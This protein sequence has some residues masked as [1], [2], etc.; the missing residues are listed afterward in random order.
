MGPLVGSSLLYISYRLCG[1]IIYAVPS[2]FAYFISIIVV[3]VCVMAF[4]TEIPSDGYHRGHESVALRPDNKSNND[5]E[6]TNV[7]NAIIACMVCS[8]LRVCITTN[9]ECA[10]ALILEEEY[11][12]TAYEAGFTISITLLSCI[13]ARLLWQHFAMFFLTPS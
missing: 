7:S 10:M 8:F 4:P 5:D 12:F 9:L 13:P 3:V 6:G 2:A 11:G 1:E